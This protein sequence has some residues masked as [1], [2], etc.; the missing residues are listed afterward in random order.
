MAHAALHKRGEI[1]AR[2][3]ALSAA[4]KQQCR[5]K[6]GSLQIKNTGLLVPREAAG[7]L[8]EPCGVEAA[9]LP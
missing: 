7:G 8:M 4:A 6:H 2:K 5:P 9:G 1:K 3:V